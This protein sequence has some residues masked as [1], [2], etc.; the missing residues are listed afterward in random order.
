MALQTL[1]ANPA[2]FRRRQ[3]EFT[4]VAPEIFDLAKRAIIQREKARQEETR[5]IKQLQNGVFP[6]DIKIYCGQWLIGENK[7]TPIFRAVAKAAGGERH[8]SRWMVANGICAD[9]AQCWKLMF[10]HSWRSP[11]QYAPPESPFLES[12]KK[13]DDYPQAFSVDDKG[14]FEVDDAFSVRPDNEGGFW[15]GVHIAVPAL[16]ESLFTNKLYRKNRLTSVYFPDAKYP[17]LPKTYTDLYSLSAGD[18]HLALSLY[19]R[20]NP[21]HANANDKQ[22]VVEK[23]YVKHNYCPEDFACRPPDAVASEYQI[24]RDFAETLPPSPSHNRV[25]F[26]IDA[27]Q[28]TVQLSER[29]DVSLLIEKLMRYVNSSWSIYLVPMGG[30]F[31]FEGAT[32]LR[33]P[34]DGAAYAWMSSP[35]RR[36][37]DLAN[38][39]LLLSHLKFMPPPTIEWKQ[40]R[41]AYSKQQ[42]R[43]RDY[44]TMMERHWILQALNHLPPNTIL[45]GVLQEKNKIRL[46]Q[47]PIAGKIMNTADT[48]TF[49]IGDEVKAQIQ[50][51]DFHYQ[52]VRFNIV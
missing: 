34:K 48:K 47:Y 29:S 42:S 10:E 7:N 25:N 50:D 41:S 35:L 52:R 27:E 45:T 2:Y 40:L 15:I 17:M 11:S 23:I 21:R 4:P 8:I 19:C 32:V 31:R 44:Q 28:Q 9:A 12:I 13:T 5:L 39:R 30:L 36:F 26:R 6:A 37:I 51:L 49:T 3:D 20:F 14:T 38:Q 18:Y 22:T 1:L 46:S 16:E 43:A 33:P 24:L